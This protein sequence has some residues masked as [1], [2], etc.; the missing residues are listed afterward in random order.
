MF[1]KWLSNRFAAVASGHAGALLKQ[2]THTIRVPTGC[3]MPK[4]SGVF[5]ATSGRSST[6]RK[7]THQTSCFLEIIPFVLF[8]TISGLTTCSGGIIGSF[9]SCRASAAALLV[10]SQ[11]QLS[12]VVWS[13]RYSRILIRKQTMLQ[14]HFR[15][16]TRTKIPRQHHCLQNLM[17]VCAGRKRGLHDPCKAECAE[18]QLTTYRTSMVNLSC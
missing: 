15:N 3:I 9:W 5:G 6:G 18:G 17:L 1:G 16:C 4:T 2:Q 8:S 7:S 13:R 10:V 12:C 11:H 14:L